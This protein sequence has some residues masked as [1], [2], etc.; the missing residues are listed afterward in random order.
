MKTASAAALQLETVAVDQLG[1]SWEFFAGLGR[2]GPGTRRDVVVRPGQIEV[3]A[4]PG[5]IVV[6][7][8]LPSG[9]Y[10]TQVIRE[11]T[12]EPFFKVAG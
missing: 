2:H 4:A 11:L 7:F 1:L 10:A 5:G 3:R 12:R 8:D 9:S 6:G